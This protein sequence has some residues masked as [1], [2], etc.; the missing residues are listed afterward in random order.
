[1]SWYDEPERDCDTRSERDDEDEGPE[2]Y[3]A[4]AYMPGDLIELWADAPAI[5]KPVLIAT[6]VY[7]IS[8]PV[9][10]DEAAA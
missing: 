5:P 1:M 7:A 2:W 9:D 6:E 10:A 3:E 4:D 8:L